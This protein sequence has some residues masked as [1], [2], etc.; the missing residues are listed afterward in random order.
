MAMSFRR[1]PKLFDNFIQAFFH[2]ILTL[3]QLYQCV[4]SILNFDS[5]YMEENLFYNRKKFKKSKKKKKQEKQIA[6]LP[7]WIRRRKRRKKIKRRERFVPTNTIYRCTVSGWQEDDIRSSIPVYSAPYSSCGKDFL[8]LLFSPE[9][10]DNAVLF[11]MDVLG[12]FYFVYRIPKA[13][14]TSITVSVFLICILDH[15]TSFITSSLKQ[16]HW[17]KYPMWS[18]QQ[19]YILLCTCIKSLYTCIQLLCT[20]IRYPIWSFEQA[21]LLLY[22]RIPHDDDELGDVC[23]SKKRRTDM[24]FKKKSKLKIMK[25][26][27]KKIQKNQPHRNSLRKVVIGNYTVPPGQYFNKPNRPITVPLCQHG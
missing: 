9:N 14:I 13:L 10:L 11:F 1:L 27:Q 22:N 25:S 17:V 21:F 2:P 4:Y 19:V 15:I 24:T 23:C 7:A 26:K 12:I 6:A 5:T 18:M 8:D 20:S 16:C 3:I